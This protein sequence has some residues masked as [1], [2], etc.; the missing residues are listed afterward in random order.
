[1]RW[2]ATR[3]AATTAAAAAGRAA[4]RSPVGFLEGTADPDQLRLKWEA[5]DQQIRLKLLRAAGVDEDDADDS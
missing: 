4:S 1:V 3:G 2:A 5:F